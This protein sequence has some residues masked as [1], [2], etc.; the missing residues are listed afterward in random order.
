ML[1]YKY[2]VW[3][4]FNHYKLITEHISHF[5]VKCC[6]EKTDA[7]ELCDKIENTWAGKFQVI[8]SKLK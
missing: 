8:M 6:M 7:I 3:L 5:T 4:V 2:G 1:G